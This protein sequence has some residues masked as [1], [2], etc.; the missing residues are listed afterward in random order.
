M[1]VDEHGN[2]VD[3]DLILYVCGKYLKSQGQ[4]PGNTVVTTVMSNMGLYEAFDK[5]GICYEKTAVGD[6]YVSENMRTNGYGLG[7]EE[8]GHI[9]FS[10]HAVTGDGILTSLKVMEA[11]LEQKETLGN[12]IKPV[13]IFPKLLVNVRVK[14]KEEVLQNEDIKNAVK[15]AEEEMGKEGRML[16]RASGTE[17]LIRVM[18][19]AKTEEMCK[20]YVDL[21]VNMIKEKGFEEN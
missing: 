6:K 7:G 16:F 1:A 17:P 15:K 11:I 12:L 20:K 18:V 10:K 4:L 8:S 13:H 2:I 14:N 3:G 9:I 5:E 21:V 19:E